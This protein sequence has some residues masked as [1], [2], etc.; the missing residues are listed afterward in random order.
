M[1]DIPIVTVYEL[2]GY[3]YDNAYLK[4]GGSATFTELVGADAQQGAGALP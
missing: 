4:S 1:F 3:R 2:C